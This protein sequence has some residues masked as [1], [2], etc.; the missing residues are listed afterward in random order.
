MCASGWASSCSGRS[1]RSRRSGGAGIRLPCSP[2]RALSR[3]SS[4]HPLVWIVVAFNAIA[5]WP[6]LRAV[7]NL[8]DDAY[9]LQL[10]AR[11]A[12]A[13][14]NGEHPFD[15]WLP[16]LELGFPV[17]LYYQ[18]IPHLAVV[19]LD[20]LTLGTVQ[21]RTM[22]DLVRYALLVTLPLTAYASLR[23]MGFSRT[24]AAAGAA[25]R[26]LFSSD[27][28]FGIEY[29]SYLW[30]GYGLYTQLWA[31]HLSFVALAAF[32][33]LLQRGG[34]IVPA[35]LAAAGVV[36]VHLLYGYMLAIS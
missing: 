24:G 27:H 23:W 10:V 35:V 5:L 16:D 2:W 7:P 33:R 6:E 4:V 15:N 19:A 11:A 32:Y 3:F 9:H 30:R 26:A 31:V 13:I 18:Q 28:R 36:L 25:A 22:F 17:F 29:D 12:D 14:A 34:R 20:W 1:R 21:L 8:N